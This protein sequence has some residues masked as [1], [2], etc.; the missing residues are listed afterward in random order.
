MK[1]I[2]M[3]VLLLLILSEAGA[4]L[5]SSVRDLDFDNMTYPG[6]EQFENAFY[7]LGPFTLRDGEDCHSEPRYT[8]EGNLCLSLDGEVG[9]RIIFGDLT[10]DGAEEAI[11][12]IWFSGGNWYGRHFY[13][14]A[15]KNGQPHFLWGM[16]DGDLL[17]IYFKDGGFFVEDSVY[18]QNDP[19]CCPSGYKKTF[20]KWNGKTFEKFGK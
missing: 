11:V 9:R 3:M 15:L 2:F 20:F 12:Q 5:G 7:R 19:R 18:A 10:G 16:E 1:K 8:S 6:S 13:I 14:I 17:S 4:A